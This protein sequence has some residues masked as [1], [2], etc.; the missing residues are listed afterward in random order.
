MFTKTGPQTVRIE[1]VEVTSAKYTKKEDAFAFC[2]RVFN[3]E[4]PEETDNVFIDVSM[5]EYGHGNLSQM[6]QYDIAQ[7]K[8]T[9]LGC[10]DV[11]EL[12]DADEITRICDHFTGKDAVVEFGENKYNDK[13]S[14]EAKYFV[15]GRSQ[16]P[17]AKDE[18]MAKLKMQRDAVNGQAP[19]TPQT[20]P[21]TDTTQEALPIDDNPFV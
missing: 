9:D 17:M 5:Q 6:I 15:T 2:F 14:I 20:A 12:Y 16:A 3:P 10:E 18:L 13:V 21:T 7:K 11:G 19:A 8:L 1:S 4:T